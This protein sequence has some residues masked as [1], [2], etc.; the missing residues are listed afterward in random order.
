MRYAGGFV[1]AFFLTVVSLTVPV[2]VNAEAGQELT[3][4]KVKAALPELEKLAEKALRDSGIPGMAIAVV[5]KDQSVYLKGFGVREAGKAERVDTDTIFQIASMSKPIA[6]TVLAVLAGEK[7][8]TW[9]DRIIDLDPGFRMYDPWVTQNVTLRDMFSHRSGLQDH[10]GDEL[11]D[12]GYDRAEILRR[13]RYLKPGSSFRSHYAYTNFGITE[14]AVAAAR[15]AGKPWEELSAEKLYRPLGMGS[16]SSRFD[17][18]AAAGNRALLHVRIDGKWVARHTR[19]A[20]AQSP[21]GGVSSSVRDLAQWLRLQLGK[22]RLDGKQL[23]DANALAETHRPVVVTG[24]PADPGRDR[25][26]LY[27]LGWNV[28][29]DDRG[30]VILSHSGAFSMG[31]ATTVVLIPS[32]DL[33]ITVLTNAFPIGI[34][35]ALACCFIDLTHHGKVEKD[36]FVLFKRAFEAMFNAMASDATDYSKPPTQPLPSLPAD[37]YAGTY[38]NEYFGDIRISV[39][40]KGLVLQLGPRKTL[41]PLNHYDRDIFAYLQEGEA[42]DS[43]SGVVFRI[44]PDRKAASAVVEGLNEKGQGTFI[45]VP[46]KE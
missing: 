8:I 38:R 26:D 11:E 19:N 34:P 3:L 15:A 6:S 29:Y 40:E 17:D 30:R 7:V 21:A 18:I 25:A 43:L 1:L 12:M 35:E 5:Y 41:Y 31:A 33:G 37:A 20:D 22:G 42:A 9:D 14:A 24:P 28:R 44:G 2:S 4:E 32:E 36:W 27:A 10:A 46:A 45:R 13:L 39:K 23:V 16:T